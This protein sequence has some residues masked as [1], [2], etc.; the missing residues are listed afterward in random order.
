MALKFNYD[1]Q[2]FYLKTI[3]QMSTAQYNFVRQFLS[4]IEGSAYDGEKYMWRIPLSALDVVLERLEDMTVFDE[5][6]ENVKGI[7][8]NLTPQFPVLDIF[9]DE[10]KLTPFPYQKI[11]ISFL[12][13]QKKA[14]VGDVMGL[15][16]TIQAIGAAHVLHRQGHV[17][18]VLVICPASLKYQWG[19]EIDK[20]TNYTSIV[21]DGTTK[22]RE[23]QYKTYSEGGIMYCLLNYE[24]V[25]NDLEIL[26][27]MDFDIIVVDE[28]HRIKNRTSQT[29][30]ALIQLDAPYKFALTGTPMQNRPEEIHA[31]MSWVEKSALGPITKFRERHVVTGTK[32]G[33]RFVPLGAKRLGEIRRQIS[34]YMIRRTKEEVAPDLPPLIESQ[35]YVDLSKE[36]KD[37]MTNIHELINNFSN[38]VEAYYNDNPDATSH[39]KENQVMGF[40]GMMISASDH[41]KLLALSNSQMAQKVGRPGRK[42][43]TSP[44]L[45][46]LL[47]LSHEQLDSGT[48]K[49][50]VFTQFARMKKLID[51]R[52][53]LEF[54][55]EAVCAGIEGSMKPLD[56]QKSLMDFQYNPER[57][58]FVCTDAANYGINISYAGALFNFD[59]P[60]NPSIRAQR[61]GR[62]HRIDGQL[63]R[64]NIIDLISNDSID[65]IIWSVIQK[66][67]K[68]GE[69]I[70]GKN[71]QE[72]ESM[73]QLM[74]LLK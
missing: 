42:A 2:Y 33:R 59:L 20:F 74:R 61:N 7:V 57:K 39:P 70:V 32:F 40:L 4:T 9:L 12:V 15:G 52:L 25:R 3:A 21:I 27:Q 38:E 44:K 56:R 36:Q 17:Q 49:I 50:V 46:A 14:V 11:G 71:K 26:K 47:E 64:Y 48:H 5:P 67:E 53:K 68:L 72:K 29:Y 73:R 8:E 62:I 37:V 60:W 31:L 63:E 10:L 34:P 18:K 58:F 51:E 65:E 69:K 45:E 28:A 41:P 6:I 16:K 1:E 66:K 22:K 24:L 43:L 55:E 35:Y 54:G 23:K 19:N 13:H 30:K